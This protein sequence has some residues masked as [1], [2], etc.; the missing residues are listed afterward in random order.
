MTK[1]FR[2]WVILSSRETGRRL[3]GEAVARGEITAPADMETVLDM[4]YPPIFYRL[5]AGHLQLVIHFADSLVTR[6]LALLARPD[7]LARMK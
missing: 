3:I 1:A 7:G 6:T 5:L 2:N 4:I